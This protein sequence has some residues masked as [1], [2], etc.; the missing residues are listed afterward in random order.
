M[1]AIIDVS[2]QPQAFMEE[3]N[4]MVSALVADF[5]EIEHSLK[6]VTIVALKFTSSKFDLFLSCKLA[7]LQV[8]IIRAEE[9][10][11]DWQDASSKISLDPVVQVKAE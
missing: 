1:T 3:G 6:I 2:R 7:S 4:E 10:A 8:S 9:T 11:I 5:F